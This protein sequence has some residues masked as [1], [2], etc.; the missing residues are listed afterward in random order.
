MRNLNLPQN[1][2]PP[3]TP[4][5]K[6]LILSIVICSILT[7]VVYFGA[8]YGIKHP[9]L[10]FVPMA[11]SVGFWIS[12]AVLLLIFII[13]NRAFTRRKLTVEMLPREWTREQK[14]SYI[15]DGKDRFEKSKWM[16]SLIIPLLVPIALDALYLFTLPLL[17]GLL[18][19]SF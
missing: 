1:N 7:C 9:A 18:H 11:V 12:F 15:K 13:Y 10:I 2:R 3:L 6:K 19:I 4:E 17:E 5:K 8:C 14:E 16:L